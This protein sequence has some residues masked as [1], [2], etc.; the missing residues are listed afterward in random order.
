MQHSRMAIPSF[1]RARAYTGVGM[2]V[3]IRMYVQYQSIERAL[4]RS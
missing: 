1:P 4:C 3:Y 2:C